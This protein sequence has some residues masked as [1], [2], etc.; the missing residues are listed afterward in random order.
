MNK[1]FLR[2]VVIF[3]LFSNSLAIGFPPTSTMDLS[4]T[5]IPYFE[6]TTTNNPDPGAPEL[7]GGSLYLLIGG[8]SG[9]LFWV[10]RFFRK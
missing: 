6:T 1:Y 5:T 2:V 10:R 7:P 8:A 4:T 9:M 3:F